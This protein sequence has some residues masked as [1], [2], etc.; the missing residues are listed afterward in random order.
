TS[1]GARVGTLAYMSPEQA[2]GLPHADARAD[3]FALGAVLYQCLS[4]RKAF[5]ADDAMA[6]IGKILLA[7][8]EPLGEACPE[9][10]PA[11]VDLVERMLAK[12][13]ARRPADGAAAAAE[14]AGIPTLGEPAPQRPTLTGRERRLVCLV[15]A[16][17][18]TPVGLEHAA[19]AAGGHLE[20]LVDGSL[21][22]VVSG[23]GAATDLAGRAARLALAIKASAPGAAI[24]V[25]TGRGIVAAGSLPLAESIDRAARLPGDGELTEETRRIDEAPRARGGPVRLDDVTA[26]L[27]DASFDVG[28]DAMGLVLRGERPHE[29]RRTLLGRETPCV[30]RDAEL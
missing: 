6:L 22:V 26:G 17:G 28:G 14:L 30:A 23:A 5:H 3:V 27:L 9:A 11:F 24:A 1:A 29:P 13:P 19:S 16:R 2:R 4:G 18:A 15:L 12:D 25:A 20:P 21:V 7:D 10:P 8:P